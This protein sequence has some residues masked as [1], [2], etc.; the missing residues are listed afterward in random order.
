MGKEKRYFRRYRRKLA[1]NISFDGTTLDAVALDY[2]ITGIGAVMDKGLRLPEELNLEIKL[3]NQ[4]VQMIGRVAWRNETSEGVRVG[5]ELIG[6]IQ[7]SLENY[8]LSDL[9]VGI[10][11]TKKIGTL[12]ITSGSYIKKIYIKNGD[13]IF[14]TSDRDEDRLGTIL[15]QENKITVEQYSQSIGLMKETGKQHGAALVELGYI[16]PHDLFAALKRQ[17]EKIIV[18]LFKLETGMFHFHEGRLPVEEVI[19]LNLSAANLV[20]KGIKDIKDADVIQG[21]FPSFKAVLRLSSDP[22]DLFQDIHLDADDRGVLAYVD[23]RSTI[24]DIVSLSA[25]DKLETLK[26]LYM[27]VSASIIIDTSEMEPEDFEED[28]DLVAEVIKEAKETVGEQT[29]K[30]PEEFIEKVE[31]LYDGLGNLGYYEILELTADA[32]ISDIKRSYYK[33][34]KDFHPDKHFYLNADMKGKLSLIFSYITSAYST[35]SDP[36]KREEYDKEKSGKIDRHVSG[37]ETAKDKFS[38]GMKKFEKRHYEDA[39]ELFG[40]AGYMNNDE[41]DYFFYY[42]LSLYKL[43]KLK[44]AEGA[45]R[46]A[47][48]M[49]PAHVEYLAEIGHIY[50]ELGYP[51]RAKSN[52]EKAL[53]T[54][55]S[56]KRT[57]E[58]MALLPDDVK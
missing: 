24:D 52:F 43:G 47:L 33:M 28:I 46:N 17:V 22:L 42:G 35:I 25:L 13:M 10:Q 45:I 21:F 12:E 49:K 39:A 32:S 4:P 1:F 54:R 31:E 29:V 44:E 9:L 23:G 5:I 16:K 14:A 3:H 20:Y 18:D 19:K 41:P 2:S 11:R 37:I 56:H 7:G 55:P 34:A 30:K 58:G 15:L 36:Q 40:Q 8:K 51:L 38:Q 57:L 53:K 26:I 27:L 50:L 6:P 48:K